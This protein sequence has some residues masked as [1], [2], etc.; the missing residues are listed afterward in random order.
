MYQMALRHQNACPHKRVLKW[1][2]I[3]KNKPLTIAVFAIRVKLHP[4]K[5]ALVIAVCRKNIE[6]IATTFLIQTVAD[7]YNGKP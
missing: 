5:S 1:K 4:S 6:H 3:A 2:C 7:I